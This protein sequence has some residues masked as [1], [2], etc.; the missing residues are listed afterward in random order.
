MKPLSR[1]VLLSALVAAMASMSG[2]V[3]L[4]TWERSTLMSRVMQDSGAPLEASFEEH[5]HAVREAVQGA[6]AAA[7]S[8]CGCN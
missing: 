8:S 7:G 1:G 5:V 4:T 6:T 3:T 2:C